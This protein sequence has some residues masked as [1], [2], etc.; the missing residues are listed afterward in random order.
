MADGKKKTNISSFGLVLELSFSVFSYS[1]VFGF[2]A[3]GLQDRQIGLHGCTDVRIDGWMDGW[4]DKRMDGWMRDG[5]MN[6]WMDG[7]MDEGWK[8]E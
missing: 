8:H 7:Q 3:G 6:G 5:S 1:S 2:F 4:M